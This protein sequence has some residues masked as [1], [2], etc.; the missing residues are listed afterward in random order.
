MLHLNA[1]VPRVH[2]VAVRASTWG[3]GVI[4]VLGTA[5]VHNSERLREVA[6]FVNIF[7][8]PES[9]VI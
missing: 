4:A 8:P 6:I 1:V 3:V 7:S 9:S 5:D 2:I